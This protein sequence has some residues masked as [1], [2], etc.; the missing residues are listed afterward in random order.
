MAETFEKYEQSESA[1][2]SRKRGSLERSSFVP[3]RQ[4]PVLLL[5]RSINMRKCMLQ[6]LTRFPRFVKI[7]FMAITHL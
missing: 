5:N 4:I 1:K 3:R 6:M 7:F 2:R